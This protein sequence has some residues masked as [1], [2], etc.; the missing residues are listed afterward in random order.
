MSKKVEIFTLKICPYCD[1]VKDLMKKHGIE[2]EEVR[3]DKVENGRE[4]VMKKTGGARSVPQIVVDG[5]H[6]GD[7]EVLFKLERDGTLKDALT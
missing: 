3:I 1:Q 7:E 6:I 5:L 4:L 2:F